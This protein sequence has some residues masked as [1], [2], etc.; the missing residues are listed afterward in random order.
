MDQSL[1]RLDRPFWIESFFSPFFAWRGRSAGMTKTIA[2]V[3]TRGSKGRKQLN[4]SKQK[5]KRGLTLT[6]STT[7]HASSNRKNFVIVKTRKQ[8]RDNR[9]DKTYDKEAGF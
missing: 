8:N 9:I 4:A 5:K 2:V 6:S 1:G 7:F 3:T